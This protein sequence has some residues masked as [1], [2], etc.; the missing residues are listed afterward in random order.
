MYYVFLVLHVIDVTFM[1]GFYVNYSRKSRK[2]T[3]KSKFNIILVMITNAFCL[4]LSVTHPI[5]F[6]N[7]ED[8]AKFS[9]ILHE[10]R[11]FFSLVFF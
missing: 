10:H 9:W 5:L 4:I 3:G 6:G 7:L 1:Q 2:V 8:L 11:I